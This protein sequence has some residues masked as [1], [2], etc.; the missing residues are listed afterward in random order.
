M[1]QALLTG[2]A[3]GALYVLISVGFALCKEIADIVNVAHGAFVLGGMYITLE[4]VRQGVPLVLA[5]AIAT[6]GIG[7]ACYPVY[8]LLIRA[9]RV[10]E[11]HGAQLMFTLLLFSALTVV[12]QLFFTA[13][14]QTIGLRFDSVGIFGAYLNT[15]QLAAILLAVLISVA[16]YLV[17]RFTM[18]GKFAYVASRYP[19][20][21]RSIGVPVDR[22]Y[23]GVFVL[24]GLLAGLAGAMMMTT[25]PVQ[26]SLGLELLTMMFL[27][28]LVARTHILWVLILGIAYGMTQA[29]FSYLFDGSIAAALT[30]CVFLVALIAGRVPLVLRSALS[31]FPALL[32]GQ[33]GGSR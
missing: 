9:A 1:T 24:S 19:L 16:L 15:A 27:V 2:A 33:A 31:V 11:G 30:S 7:A 22:I 32:P 25:Q 29:A 18:L 10:Q 23:A 5:A 12:Y 3:L 26:P 13:D 8:V 14:L 28:S 20:G 17:S 21:A 6:A 4:M